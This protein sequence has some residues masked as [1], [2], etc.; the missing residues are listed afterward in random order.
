MD[1]LLS[2]DN[3]IDNLPFDTTTT[4]MPGIL[5]FTKQDGETLS[6]NDDAMHTL[7]YIQL[8]LNGF[9]PPPQ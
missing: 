5:E 7:Y 8:E 9:T 3:F 2:N 6:D 1:Y 4:I